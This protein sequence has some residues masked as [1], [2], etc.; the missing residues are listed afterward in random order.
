MR[1]RDDGRYYL[2]WRKR[3]VCAARDHTGNHPW[4]CV[5]VPPCCQ[6]S[7][8]TLLRFHSAR[9]WQE[10]C[11]ASSSPLP[12]PCLLVPFQ[13]PLG[14]IAAGGTQRL[15]RQIGKSRAMELCL[16]GEQMGA[17][18]ALKLGLCAKVKA[19]ILSGDNACLPTL[20]LKPSTTDA[21]T[22]I[23]V[24]SR[25]NYSKMTSHLCR[26]PLC[27]CFLLPRPFRP[28]LQLRAR[29]QAWGRCLSKCARRSVLPTCSHHPCSCAFGALLNLT[30]LASP[31]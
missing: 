6:F 21:N 18:E 1:G 19:N 8:C 15:V 20:V 2:C 12:P 17:E 3:K 25:C 14:S 29:S 28:P 30:I 7:R 27:R 10:P 9:P 11:Q 31:F 22:C 23:R 5:G 26:V 16:T 13:P 24:E 4:R